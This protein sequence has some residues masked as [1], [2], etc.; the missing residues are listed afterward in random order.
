[1][2]PTIVDAQSYDSFQGMDVRLLENFLD[3]AREQPFWRQSA[4][5]EADYYD[6]NQLD[7]ETLA[8][9][10]ERGMPPLVFNY[11]APT[12][13]TVLGMEAKTRTD[14]RV[15]ANR[16]GDKQADDVAEALNVRLNEAERLSRADWAVSDAYAA[17][18]KVGMGWVEV[19]R[20]S[21]PF[22]P[23]YRVGYVNRREIWWDWR[24]RHPELLDARYLFRRKWYD[25]DHLEAMFPQHKEIIHHALAG[26]PFWDPGPMIETNLASSWDIERDSSLD[27][28]EWRDTVRRRLA[29]YEV[30]YRVWV[31]GHVL[32]MPDGRVVEFDR[33]NEKHVRAVAMNAVPVEAATY[34]K[35][36]LSWWIGPHKIVDVPTPY[37]HNYFPYIPFWGYREDRTG[38]P[39]GLIRGMRSPQ[40]AIN[41]RRSK[42]MWLLN[43]KRVTA[44]DDS[45]K[46]RDH[47]SARQEVGRPDAYIILNPERRNKRAEAFKVESDLPL[48]AQQFNMLQEDKESLQDTGGIFKSML[49]KRESGAESGVAI[50]SLIEQGTMTLAEINDQY[51]MS[52]R[53][54]G[55]MLLT[56]VKEDLN[57]QSDVEV[58]IDRGLGRKK[59]VTLNQTVEDPATR[60]KTRTND[61]LRTQ[62]ILVLDDV[63][64]TPTFRAQL[65]M[66]LAELAKGLPPEI[67]PLVVDMIIEGSDVPHKEEIIE[68]VRKALGLM[69]PADMSPEERQ[70]AQQQQQQTMAAMQG[71]IDKLLAEVENL[72]AKTDKADAETALLHE[73]LDQTQVDTAGKAIETAGK[74]QEIAHQREQHER[75][76]LQPVTMKDLVDAGVRPPVAQ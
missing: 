9:M 20:E 50:N 63:P 14:W 60:T 57:K 21:D 29:L 58:T 1:M 19:G 7:S 55:E 17:Q 49:G 39:Y 8:S 59:K 45:V 30:W 10:R 35:V 36:R 65:V 51:R 69:D 47:S 31:R 52:R 68:R 27:D 67:Q 38:V 34:S 11:I 61:V 75:D 41:A 24:A 40:D 12:V 15:K 56:L 44:D 22:L 66:H 54:V 64:S 2:T 32:R 74:A 73:K 18:T 71:E 26:W 48:S 70:A 3:E 53:R 37:P 43:A 46:N 6:G 28:K 25:E 13:N 4:E 72:R 16:P 42:L 23:S 5:I 62:T 33:K 76:M